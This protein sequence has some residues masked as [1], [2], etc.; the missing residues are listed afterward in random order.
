MPKFTD[1]EV[2]ASEN[3]QNSAID[4]ISTYDGNFYFLKKMKWRM[5]NGRPFSIA[6][7]RGILNSME[8]QEDLEEEREFDVH[9]KAHQ[10]FVEQHVP[11]YTEAQIHASYANARY[12]F[13]YHK[14]KEG[15]FIWYATGPVLVV[16]PLCTTSA[17]K[18]PYLLRSR[19]IGP[20]IIREYTDEL[21]MC[22]RC[23]KL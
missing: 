18:R 11:K 16:K 2:A 6:Q 10:D 19:D 4:L 15:F 7:L 9:L 23:A 13:I 20:K 8:Y 14:I 5:E 1:E 21:T 12:S 3:L 17:L 22:K